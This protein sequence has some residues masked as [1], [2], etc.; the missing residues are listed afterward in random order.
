MKGFQQ[1]YLKNSFDKQKI[2]VNTSY[3]NFNSCCINNNIYF[4]KNQLKMHSLF[5][6]VFLF[7]DLNIFQDFSK[8]EQYEFTRFQSRNDNN[9]YPGIPHEYFRATPCVGRFFVAKDRWMKQQEG[10]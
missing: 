8:A 5:T 6:I 2:A 7:I 9:D 3:Y 1:Y 10:G 4:F